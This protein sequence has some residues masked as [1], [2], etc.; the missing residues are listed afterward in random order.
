[1]ISDPDIFRAAKL[2]IDKC[3]EG[4]PM[5]AAQHADEL[6]DDGDLDGVAIWRQILDAI[7]ELTRSWRDGESLN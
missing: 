5:R 1:M 7:D 3:G 2:L 4:A 6:A